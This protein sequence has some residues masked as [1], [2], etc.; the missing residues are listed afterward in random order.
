M[1]NLLVLEDEEGGRG[2][3]REISVTGTFLLMPPPNQS[4]VQVYLNISQIPGA[5]VS[6]RR[7]FNFD[8]GTELLGH[9]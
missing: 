3:V 4:T 5:E 1:I 9:H 2:D 8:F 7:Q 6:I